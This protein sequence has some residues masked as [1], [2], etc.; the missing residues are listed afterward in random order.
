[1]SFNIFSE[2]EI[3]DTY[4]RYVIK[5][6][7][8]FNRFTPFPFYLNKGTWK[9]EGKDFPRIPCL[10]DFKEWIEKYSINNT[11]NILITGKDDPELEFIKYKEAYYLPYTIDSGDFHTLSLEVNNFDFILF[12]QTIEHLYNP[13]LSMWN[14]YHHLKPGGFMFTSV[15][16]LNIPHMVPIHFNGFTP[17]GLGMLM[18]SVGFNILEIGYWG[19]NDYITKLFTNKNWPSYE[20]LL[21]EGNI[22]HDEGSEVQT[23]ILVQK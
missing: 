21:I 15:P 12:N 2:K 19:N 8:Y 13:F 11:E 14:L 5:P 20:D 17:I 22:S 18:K 7:E 23:W 16:V 1:M 9:W 4:N 3:H 6:K 10:L